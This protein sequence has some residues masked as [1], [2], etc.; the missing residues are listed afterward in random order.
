MK[1]RVQRGRRQLRRLLTECCQV[2]TS[3]TGGISDYEPGAHCEDH[4]TVQ[5]NQ[6]CRSGCQ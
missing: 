6:R 1:S 2:H 3:P 5:G 4:P